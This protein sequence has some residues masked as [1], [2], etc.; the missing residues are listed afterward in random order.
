MVRR[1]AE[2]PLSIAKAKLSELVRSVGKTGAEI[3]L[4]VDGEPAARLVPVTPAPR[5]L[6][7]PEI[8]MVRALMQGLTRIPRA[9]DAFDAVLLI[10]EGR[11]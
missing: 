7:A 6:T 10:N 3:V 9:P 1:A 2:V 11:R 4:T 5:R 8:T